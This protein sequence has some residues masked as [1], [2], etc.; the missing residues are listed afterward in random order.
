[1]LRSQSVFIPLLLFLIQAE[2][3]A[4]QSTALITSTTTNQ[5]S[6]GA[7]FLHVENAFNSCEKHRAHV[8]ALN[9]NIR[10]VFFAVIIPTIVLSESVTLQLECW[11]AMV[12]H[13]LQQQHHVI[14]MCL[15]LALLITNQHNFDRIVCHIHEHCVLVFCKS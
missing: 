10:V 9:L 1:M 5:A 4:T 6:K 7:H 8:F 12:I 15:F 13:S 14:S 3:F 11:F 2:P